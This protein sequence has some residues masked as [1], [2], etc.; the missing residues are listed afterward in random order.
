MGLLNIMSNC[1][2]L[3]DFRIFI[4]DLMHVFCC[5]RDQWQITVRPL[6][7]KP[8]LTSNYILGHGMSAP[9]NVKSQKVLGQPSP[10]SWSLLLN[11]L[12]YTD[13]ELRWRVSET[14]GCLD[15]DLIWLASAETSSLPLSPDFA[16][17]YLMSFLTLVETEFNPK[18]T[19]I[20]K[21]VSTHRHQPAL[22]HLWKPL[23]DQSEVDDSLFLRM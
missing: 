2:Y 9:T 21:R 13:L 19:L 20:V 18:L 8:L 6:D 17:I 11:Q 14:D 5:P 10:Q 16:F 22:L 3:R 7:T 15:F 23:Y 1:G 4:G 12:I